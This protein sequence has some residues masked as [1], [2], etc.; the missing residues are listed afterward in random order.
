MNK[1]LLALVLVLAF[2]L[3]FISCASDEELAEKDSIAINDDGTIIIISET[4]MYYV[5]N[6]VSYRLVIVD[7]DVWRSVKVMRIDREEIMIEMR[8]LVD[9]RQWVIVYPELHWR[10]THRPYCTIDRNFEAYGKSDDAPYFRPA[11]KENGYGHHCIESVTGKITAYSA[12]SHARDDILR[13]LDHHDIS[14]RN[15]K[16]KEMRRGF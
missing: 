7:S 3:S 1:A 16:S 6:G 4:S 8:T 15:P 14:P 5:G 13:I 10:D 11:F 12:T 2:S 9:G